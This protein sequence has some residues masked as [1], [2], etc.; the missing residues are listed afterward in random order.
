[1]NKIVDKFFLVGDKFLPELPLYPPGIVPVDHLRNIVK[2]FKYLEK[3][4]ISNISI[5]KNQINLVFLMMLLTLM[6]RIQLKK[7]ISDNILKD[8]AYK[9]AR[10]PKYDECQRALASMIYKGLDKKTGSEVIATSKTGASVN[11]E[12]AEELH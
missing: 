8:R 10:N 12:L 11:E 4:I 3:Q 6:E 9:I 1:M 2:E 5:K 7:T